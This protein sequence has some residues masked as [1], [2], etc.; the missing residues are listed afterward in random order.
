MHAFLD[1]ASPE[2]PDLRG[3]QSSHSRRIRPPDPHDEASEA[4]RIPL[5]AGS[6]DKTR[7]RES[8]LGLRNIFG[9]ARGG[10]D[11]DSGTVP[12]RDGPHRLGGIR[13][14]L[15]EI[16]WPHVSQSAQGH[17]SDISLPP[18]KASTT[19]HAL[20]HKK[21]ESLVRQQ[22]TPEGIAAWT[23]P[24]LFR[25][26]PQAIKHAHLPA[27]T[28]PAEVILRMH[29]HKSS[30]SLAGLLGPR[31][32]DPSEDATGDKTRS[33][34]RSNGSGSASRFEWT[35]KVY[36]LTTSRY[37]LQYAG[38]G[39]YDR[40]PERVLQLG[41]DSAAFA[42]DAI[43]G[44][45]WV[46]QVTSSVPEPDRI[47]EPPSS[48]RA[49]LPFLGQEKKHS[50]ALLMVCESAEEMEAWIATLRRE[51]EALGGRKVL[52]ETGKPKTDD[53]DVHLRRYASQRTLV[54]RDPDRFSRVMTPDQ[55]SNHSLPIMSPSPEANP[56]EQSFD[57]NSTAS[58]VSHEGRQ[59]ETLRDSYNRLSFVSSGQRTMVTSVG[60]SPAC[61]PVRDSF[62]DVDSM[63][64]A[65]EPEEPQPRPRPN[66]K[67]IIDRRQSLQTINYVLE[68]GIASAQALRPLSTYSN[69]G[70]PEGGAPSAPAPQP[71]SNVSGSHSVGK[72]HSFA[73][74]P[75]EPPSTQTTS[76]PLL[77]RMNARRPPPTALFINPRPLS[78][79]EDQ[80][81][82]AL[83]ALSRSGTATEG[84]EGPS[85]GTP[86]APPVTLPLPHQ[87]ES[88]VSKRIRDE[89]IRDSGISTQENISDQPTSTYLANRHSKDDSEIPTHGILPLEAR[90]MPRSSTSLGTY[91]ELRPAAQ[92]SGKPR[93]RG[94]GLSFNS[95]EVERSGALSSPPSLQ[96]DATQRP[97]TPSLKPV[98]RSAQQ[99]RPDPQPH[100]VPQQR[101]MSQLAAE[102]PPLAPPPNRA[103]PPIPQKPRMNSPPP[104]FI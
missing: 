1:P 95:Q 74:T 19:G 61:S 65:R 104:G 94:R 77:A 49:R 68:M 96:A 26:Y 34:H 38:E 59:L 5:R 66:A 52:S 44:R 91:G 41:K 78:L 90:E 11:A 64:E 13:A 23:P 36:V 101:S 88:E 33:R 20:K 100:M 8:R 48:L 35:S 39:T 31:L 71:V 73:R 15:A 57:D 7:K 24:P 28:L 67:A 84:S 99:L 43:P 51:I 17:R 2:S 81:S 42:S 54:R 45:H 40:L 86:L 55:S 85:S 75:G 4:V 56:R 69:P 82:P 14:S 9:R 58:F 22:P 6:G 27:C 16:S 12:T 98:P 63:P 62:G 32:S 102:G 53:E 72:R 37:L 18:Q 76:S 87:L 79:V 47:P 70:Q 29:A 46:I 93:T 83:S 92:V 25:A 97:R 80:P 89:P 30:G 21:S 60:S 103:L 3:S 10:S 50:T